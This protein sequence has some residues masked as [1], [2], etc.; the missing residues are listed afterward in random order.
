MR[1]NAISRI[2]RAVYALLIV[3]TLSG[4]S[5]IL[6][7]KDTS[8][9]ACT[10]AV[11]PHVRL[12]L[13]DW[14]EGPVIG[15]GDPGTE[16][17]KHGLEGGSVIRVD[18]VYHLFT[19]EQYNDPKWV[20][21]RLGHWTSA[22]GEN[23][24]RAATLYE[25]SGDYTGTDRRAALWSPMPVFDQQQDNW[26]II[27][28][29]YSCKPDT[30]EQFLN[31]FNGQIWMAKSDVSGIKGIGGPYTD[32]GIIMEPGPS[33]DEWEGLQ[34][35]DSFYPF[36]TGDGWIAFYGSAK[37][38][39]LPIQFWGVGLAESNKL[40]G[41][42]TRMSDRN[43]VDFKENFAENPIVTKIGDSIYIA[44]MDAHGDGF[45][46]SCSYDG[47]K[48]SEMQ[49]VNVTGKMK[50]WWS[51]FRTPLC[52]IEENDGNFSVFFTATKEETD[53][54]QHMGE[55]GYVLDTGFDSMGWLKVKLVQ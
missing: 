28:V 32:V 9:P 27:Y 50:P 7:K 29:A 12:E 41:P 16:D 54:W 18:N 35:T 53:Y 6:K 36:R 55:Q 14:F 17:I 25:S 10:E 26:Y 22:D 30:K 40:Q 5:G 31:N 19:S 52:L 45:G 23:W 51:E 46:Y 3:I 37:T 1:Q 43:P 15:K 33:S 44:V 24:I 42:W 34:G 4:C 48:W 38:E 49:H 47:L 8:P 20:K 21:M 39:K 2:F 11:F 13:V